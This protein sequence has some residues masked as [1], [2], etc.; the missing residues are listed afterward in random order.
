MIGIVN[1]FEDFLL[2]NIFREIE[3]GHEMGQRPGRILNESIADLLQTIY[4]EHLQ[5]FG[6]EALICWEGIIL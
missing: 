1:K 4:V 6:E 5:G 2:Q 3:V